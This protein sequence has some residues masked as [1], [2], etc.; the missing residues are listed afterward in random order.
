MILGGSGGVVFRNFFQNLHTTMGILA[1][2]GRLVAQILLFCPDSPLPN[3]FHIAFSSHIFDL[4]VAKS[5]FAL[6]FV[7]VRNFI[8][9]LTQEVGVNIFHT[10]QTP[11]VLLF[12]S[13]FVKHLTIVF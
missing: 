12:V 10:T 3:I 9:F 8:H 2:L 4:C 13:Y 11:T 6:K 7:F 1:L 5:L